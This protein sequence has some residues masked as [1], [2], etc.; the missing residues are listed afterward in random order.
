MKMINTKIRMAIIS[1]ISDLKLNISTIKRENMDKLTKFIESDYRLEPVPSISPTA[2]CII[3]YIKYIVNSRIELIRKLNWLTRW[4]S[5]TNAKDIGNLYLIYGLSG[6]LIGTS[7][8]SIIRI[9]LSKPGNTFI[10]SGQIYNSVITSHAL[11]M[12]FYFIMPTLL[13]AFGNYFLPVFI[14]S[15]DMS[16]PRLN[17]LSLFLMFPSILLLISGSLVDFGAG[18]GWTLYPPLSISDSS[19]SIDLSIFALHIAGI[20]SLLGAVNFICTADNIRAYNLHI[21]Y[22]AL[23]VW[24]VIVTAVLLLLSLPVLAACL[25][26]LITDRNLNTTFFEPIGGGDP[27]LYQHLF[28]IFGFITLILFI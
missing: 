9:Q 24:T 22:Y 18:L 19:P 7:L 3:H 8:S 2:D 26:M 27:I 16:F 25:T 17:N 23:F 21:A 15:P 28:L 20:S 5:S 1:K 13:G 11:I 12:I 10:L 4:F 6:A 14:G